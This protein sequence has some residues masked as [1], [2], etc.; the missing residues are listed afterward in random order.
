MNLHE[1]I[2]GSIRRL[3]HIQRFSSLPGH[4]PESVAEH[5]FFVAFYGYLIAQDLV[6]DGHEVYPDQVVV[7]A[8]CHDLSEAMSGDIIRSFKY[9]NDRIK[10]EVDLADR[11][12]MEKMSNEFGD[13]KH[14]IMENWLSSK[15]DAEGEVVKFADFVCV[16]AYCREEIA[17]GNHHLDMILE[18]VFDVMWNYYSENDYFSKYMKQIFPNKDYKDAFRSMPESWKSISAT[19]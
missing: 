8:I 16:I 12:N 17:S 5:S 9:S 13:L 1:S 3:R 15:H 19:R 18:G 11:E 2:N 14:H 10:H 7:K 6:A 4:F